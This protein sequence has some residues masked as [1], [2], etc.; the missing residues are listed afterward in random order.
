MTV[1]F[2]RRDFL[3]LAGAATLLG[4]AGISLSAVLQHEADAGKIKRIRNNPRVNIAPCDMRGGL[5][6]SW[7]AARVEILAGAEDCNNPA[8]EVAEERDHGGR[9]YRD[10][11]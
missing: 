10:S 8:D 6:G 9:F 3:K 7:V 11:R 5:K 1:A 2:D 4:E